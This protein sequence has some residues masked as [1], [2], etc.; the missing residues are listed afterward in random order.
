[1]TAT[2]VAEA[3]NEV[4]GVTEVHDLHVWTVSPGYVSLSSHVVLDDQSLSEAQEIMDDLKANLAER[5]GIEH[6]TIQ[7]ECQSCA[8]GTIICPY[9]VGD[10]H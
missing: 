3:M 5:F 7:V 2:Q 4:E 10:Q 9:E 1:M 6:T 8:E